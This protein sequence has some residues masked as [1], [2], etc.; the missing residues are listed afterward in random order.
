MS[1]KDWT[2]YVALARRLIGKSLALSLPTNSLKLMVDQEQHDKNYLWIDPP[3]DL[4]Q[5]GVRKIGAADY[6][7]PDGREY[8]ALHERW[9]MRVRSLLE[10]AVLQT[11]ELAPDG[12]VTF[13]FQSGVAL[14]VTGIE[15]DPDETRW[16]DNWYAK[17]D[18]WPQNNKMQQTSHG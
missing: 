2:D 8:V 3:W 16:Y 15:S 12:G 11:V 6:P 1:A 4:L 13:T 18:D 17:G 5:A 9:G 7:D 14:A 10:G